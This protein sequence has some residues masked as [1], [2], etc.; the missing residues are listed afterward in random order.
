MRN[1]SAVYKVQEKQEKP[2]S[3]HLVCYRLHMLSV[4][5]SL[6][7][8]DEL[9]H[10]RCRLVQHRLFLNHRYLKHIVLQ[11]WRNGKQTRGWSQQKCAVFPHR[12]VCGFMLPEPLSPRGFNLAAIKLILTWN[13]DGIYQTLSNKGNKFTE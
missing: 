10:S 9:R 13:N 1:K 4:N 7:W 12:S 11:Q 3:S 6:H 8:D 5:P 2:D